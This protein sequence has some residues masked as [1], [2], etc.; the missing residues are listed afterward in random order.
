MRV[1]LT[2][3][4]AIAA[5]GKTGPS[6]WPTE[7][8]LRTNSPTLLAMRMFIS[9]G[10][11]AGSVQIMSGQPDILCACTCGRGIVRPGLTVTMTRTEGRL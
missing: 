8:V 4:A 7:F 1:K 3:L 11:R 9:A 10:T 5:G 6:G 2:E